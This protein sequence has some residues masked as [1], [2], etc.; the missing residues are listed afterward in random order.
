MSPVMTNDD[1]SPEAERRLDK[2]FKE[3]DVDKDGKI[4]IK[5]LT[6]ALE[7]RGYRASKQNAQVNDLLP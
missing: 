3:I 2:L 5:D 4:D 1:I 6:T 7:K